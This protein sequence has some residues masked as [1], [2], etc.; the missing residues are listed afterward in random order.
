MSGR[1][2]NVTGICKRSR[3][4]HS[5]L[6]IVPDMAQVHFTS[7]LRELVPDAP[8][9]VPGTTVGEALTHLWA[10]QP[11]VRGYVLDDQGRLRK[12]VCIFA[13]GARLQA[14]AALEHRINSDSQLYVMQA[15]TG[16]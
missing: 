15:L 1:W 4:D 16:G 5:R 7:W 9:S 8:L 14:A 10:Q 2:I 6:H 11:Q 12:H 13:D 3:F